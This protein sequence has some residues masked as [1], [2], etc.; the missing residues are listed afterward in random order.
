MYNWKSPQQ[1]FVFWWV[2]YKADIE[3]KADLNSRM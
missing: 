2:H 1:P 3:Q